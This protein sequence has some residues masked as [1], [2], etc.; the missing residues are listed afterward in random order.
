MTQPTG[1][2]NGKL[3][4]TRSCFVCGENNPH[5]LHSRSRIEDGRV[6]IDYTTRE[7]DRGYRHIMHGGLAVTLLDEVM[8][9]AAISATGR[10]C[11]AAELNARLKQPIRVPEQLRVEGW[12]TRV[13]PRLILTEGRIIGPDGAERL[14]ATGKYIPM[15]KDQI[16]LTEKD[17]VPSPET[18]PPSEIVGG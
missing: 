8:T 18:I 14:A 15:P 16:E 3:P 2:L 6:V 13:T 9:W 1:K 11:V 7:A 17:F 12:T 5:G 4:W 10:V